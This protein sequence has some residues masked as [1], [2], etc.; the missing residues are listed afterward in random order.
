M[1]FAVMPYVHLAQMRLSAVPESVHAHTSIQG[2][3]RVS[4]GGGTKG[5]PTNRW[6]ELLRYKVCA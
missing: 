6:A 2:M 4:W 1:C 5:S 3:Q